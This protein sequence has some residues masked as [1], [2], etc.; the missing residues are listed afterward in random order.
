MEKVRSR[1]V[2]KGTGNGCGGRA[3]KT[4]GIEESKRVRRVEKIESRI[5]TSPLVP[6]C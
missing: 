6:M 4:R 5:P 1:K 3:V 2:Q